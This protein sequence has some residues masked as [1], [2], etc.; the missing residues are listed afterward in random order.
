MPPR[1]AIC[2]TRAFDT[3][4]CASTLPGWLPDDVSLRRVASA[5]LVP[6]RAAAA[7][8]GALAAALVRARGRV[9]RKQGGWSASL[10]DPMRS[11]TK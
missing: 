6:A 11:S 8:L 9:E 10:R 5:R 1:G 2:R 3:L 7:E 4:A